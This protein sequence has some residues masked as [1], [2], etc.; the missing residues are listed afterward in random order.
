MDPAYVGS[1][2]TPVSL[3]VVRAVLVGGSQPLC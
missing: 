1:R 3:E 2:M